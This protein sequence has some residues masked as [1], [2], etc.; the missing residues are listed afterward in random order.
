M[1]SIQQPALPNFQSRWTFG[2]H[3]S[4]ANTILVGFPSL[5]AM[6][7]F[8]LYARTVRCSAELHENIHASRLARHL[9]VVCKLKLLWV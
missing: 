5:A 3:S 6:T 1:I 8:G 9:V 7:R 2:S 4:I